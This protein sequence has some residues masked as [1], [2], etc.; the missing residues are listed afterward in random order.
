[1]TAKALVQSV[2]DMPPG[3]LLD[4]AGTIAPNG[5]VMCDGA[6]ISRTTY[7]NLFAATSTAYGAGDGSTTFNLPDFRGRFAR[8]NDDMGTG[9]ASR[10]T[11]RVHGSTQTQ[12]T[13]VNGLSVSGGG[14]LLISGHGITVSS[15]GFGSDGT[16]FAISCDSS[17]GGAVGRQLVTASASIGSIQTE[18]RPI[19]LNCNRIIKT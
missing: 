17:T 14:R 4:F 12:T 1:M 15:F 19:N 7:V 8:Y 6:A 9:A 2:P 3:T 5:W 10:D 13:A 16:G 11:G 18:T